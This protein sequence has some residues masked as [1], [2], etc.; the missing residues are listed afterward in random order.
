MG[1]KLFTL[2]FDPWKTTH[3]HNWMP[4]RNCEYVHFMW[5][6]TEIIAYNKKQQHQCAHAW[7]FTADADSE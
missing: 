1:R 6:E 5:G 4:A 3:I 2:L 7:I